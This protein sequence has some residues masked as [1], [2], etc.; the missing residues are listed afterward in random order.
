MRINSKRRI[1][2]ALIIA[3]L[4]ILL[5]WL[6][7]RFIDGRL[8]LD[9][10]F[11]DTGDWGSDDE[12]TVIMIGDKE[13]VTNDDLDTYLFIG[14]DGGGQDLGEALSGELAD[15]LMLL[16]IDNTTEKYAFY[17][18]DRNTMVEMEITDETGEGFS[19]QTQQICL[20]HWYGTSDDLRNQSTVNTVSSLMG[21][22]EIDNYYTINME[23]IGKVNDAIGGVM[24]DIETDMTAVDPAFVKG[25][26]VLLTGDQAEKFI[27]ARYALED[28]SNASRMARQ[29]QYMERAYALLINQFRE[30]PEYV[31][32]LYDQLGD[33]IESDGS[34]KEVSVAVNHMMQYDGQGFIKFS[35]K[36]EL[37]D[38]L[39][40][41]IKHEEFYVDDASIINGLMKV[42]DL[43]ETE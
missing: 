9:E 1:I 29:Q 5:F 23:D 42:I 14:T 43:K 28:D 7:L 40:E 12:E 10:Q 18:I 24:V 34:S 6:V 27:R 33:S 37:N 25:E 21:E 35:G 20:S 26:S 22:L 11:G 39:G 19:F 2:L 16:V 32:D 31:N 36:T 30:N 15:F 3:L 4:A 41:G 8:E 17:T 38:T 13:Y